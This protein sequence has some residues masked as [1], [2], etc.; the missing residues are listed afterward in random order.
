MIQPNFAVCVN[1]FFFKTISFFLKHAEHLFTYLLRLRELEVHGRVDLGL[2]AERLH[3][4][5]QALL[6]QGRLPHDI[7]A[8]AVLR[9][10]E[11][12][13]FPNL[14]V[15]RAVLRVVHH[16]VGVAPDVQTHGSH[17]GVHLAD[18]V[19]VRIVSPL[20]GFLHANLVIVFEYRVVLVVHRA[21]LQRGPLQLGVDLPVRVEIVHNLFEQ[22][23]RISRIGGLIQLTRRLFDQRE[24]VHIAEW[25][26]LKYVQQGCPVFLLVVVVTICQDVQHGIV[27]VQL[28]DGTR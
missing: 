7:S 15:M 16:Q 10:G 6:A 2:Y 25:N 20:L 21:Q 14:V 28:C 17:R 8:R 22:F 11:P 18:W 27:F 19:H 12:F 5:V 4:L 1:S 9:L 26:I 24:L 13:S 23:V 3:L